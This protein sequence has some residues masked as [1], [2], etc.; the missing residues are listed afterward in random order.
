MTVS[1]GFITTIAGTGSIGSSAD[2]IPAVS[3]LFNSP[4]RVAVDVTGDIYIADTYNHKIRKV[5]I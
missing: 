5:G 1:T 4:F 3:S 2:G